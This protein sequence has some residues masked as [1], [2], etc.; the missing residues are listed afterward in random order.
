MHK[1]LK[2]YSLLMFLSVLI[3]YGTSAQ[4]ENEQERIVQINGVTMTADS[5]RAL[6]GVVVFV[7]NQNRGAVSSDQGVFSIVAY[8]GDTL[9]FTSLGLRGKEVVIPEDI[10]GHYL[11]M[12]QLMVQ[13][14]FF[15]AESIIRPFPTRE[16]FNY[17]FKYWDIPDDRYERARRNTE[18]LMLRALAYNTPKDGGENQSAYQNMQAQRAVYYGQ[19][20]PSNLFNPLA[21]GEFYE[22]WKRGDFK[23]RKY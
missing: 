4:D 16:E 10:D 11:S 23:K 7:K 12:V 21:W 19:Q 20:P 22:A 6:P 8:K 3:P 15:L 5:L 18:A 13:D 17:A 14:T 2:I 9:I 1:H